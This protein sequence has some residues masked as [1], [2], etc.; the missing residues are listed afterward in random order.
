VI[1]PC[2][3]LRSFTIVVGENLM[4]VGEVVRNAPWEDFPEGSLP[5]RLVAV[6]FWLVANVHTEIG[7]PMSQV[8]GTP[9]IGGWSVPIHHVQPAA[10]HVDGEVKL[11]HFIGSK[12]PGIEPDVELLGDAAELEDACAP[13]AP[14][15]TLTPAGHP[16][17]ESEAITTAHRRGRTSMAYPLSVSPS[18]VR[19]GEQTWNR[20]PIVA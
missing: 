9:L 4:V 7:V 16:R 3:K 8:G 10:A 14:R 6:L 2:V 17:N 12:P 15:S 18:L 5:A 1:G 19:A 13:P 20:K 11:G